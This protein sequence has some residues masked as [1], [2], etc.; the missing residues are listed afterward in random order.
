MQLNIWFKI[1]NE[2]TLKIY[3]EFYNHKVQKLKKKPLLYDVYYLAA[4]ET[5]TSD[6][7]THKCSLLP[8]FPHFK[9]L[10]SYNYA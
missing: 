10:L 5:L 2:E 3:V 4:L 9:L 1:L 6:I 8:L 7:C